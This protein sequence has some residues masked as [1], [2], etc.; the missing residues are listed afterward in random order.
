MGTPTSTSTL[1][2]TPTVRGPT[3]LIFEITEKCHENQ[4]LFIPGE[5]Q[6][7]DVDGNIIDFTNEVS[8]TALT[9]IPP[10]VEVGDDLTPILYNGLLAGYPE[11]DRYIHVYDGINPPI[12]FYWL[13]CV[14]N[15]DVSSI[16]TIRIS[17][18]A[19]KFKPA[20]QVL[21]EGNV[22]GSHPV[23]ETSGVRPGV[24]GEIPV[25]F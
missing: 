11:F 8:F 18:S 5:V 7:L 15:R 10:L 21:Y 13:E 16:K 6:F 23:G 17:Y 25:S 2:L 22:I 24:F 1:T 3:T 19:L 9:R 4:Y 12:P 14:I 20:L